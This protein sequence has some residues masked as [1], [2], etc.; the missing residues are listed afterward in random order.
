MILPMRGMASRSNESLGWV[1][2]RLVSVRLLEVGCVWGQLGLGVGLVRVTS[3][4][5]GRGIVRV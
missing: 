3:S 1:L 2:V 4:R 5:D